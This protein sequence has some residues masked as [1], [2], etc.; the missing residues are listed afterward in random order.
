MEVISRSCTELSTPIC[1][2]LEFA[3]FS[4]SGPLSVHSNC[5]VDIVE[6]RITVVLLNFFR[7]RVICVCSLHTEVLT[8]RLGVNRKWEKK[9]KKKKHKHVERLWGSPAFQPQSHKTKHWALS[10]KGQ[11]CLLFSYIKNKIK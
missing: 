2:Y 9:T 6:L 3:L 11:V 8:Y 5:W 7:N 10:L 4:K 1:A